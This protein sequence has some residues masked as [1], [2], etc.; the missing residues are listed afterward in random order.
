MQQVELSDR[1]Q[2][3][4]GP[5]VDGF[6]DKVVELSEFNLHR[7]VAGD[8]RVGAASFDL[9]FRGELHMLGNVRIDEGNQPL[10]AE[11]VSAGIVQILTREI[12][13]HDIYIAA[14]RRLWRA[15]EGLCIDQFS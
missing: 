4:T 3:N 7:A 14:E 6:I 1:H 5:E 9:D 2:K 15:Q 10:L 11:G 12:V 13:V 8:R